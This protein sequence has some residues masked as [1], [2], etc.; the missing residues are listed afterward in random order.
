MK[1]FTFKHDIGDLVY[2]TSQVMMRDFDTCTFCAGVGNITGQ[3]DVERL[4]PECYGKRGRHRNTFHQW[5]VGTSLTVGQ[6]RVEITGET[7]NR[8][9]STEEQY[10]CEETSVGSGTIHSA[11]NLH[12]SKEDAQAYCNDKNNN[13]KEMI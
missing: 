2:P 10:M 6:Q 3:D 11:E 8:T 13:T 12:A 7:Y 5:V 9:A 1:R 4:C